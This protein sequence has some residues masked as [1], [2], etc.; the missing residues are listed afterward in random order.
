MTIPMMT[1]TTTSTPIEYQLDPVIH[2]DVL[3]IV[4]YL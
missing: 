4:E 3:V 1:V 2:V